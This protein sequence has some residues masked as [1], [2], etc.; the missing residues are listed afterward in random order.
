MDGFENMVDYYNKTTKKDTYYEIINYV[1]THINIINKMPIAKI[2]EETYVSESTITRFVRK[3]GYKD[4]N[5]FKT[6]IYEKYHNDLNSSFR[7][8]NEQLFTLEKKPETFLKDYGDAICEAIQDTV[9][10]FDYLKIDLLID[11]IMYH[12]CAIFAYNQPLTHAKEI[13]NDFIIKNKL[14][15]VGETYDKQLQIASTLNKNSIA[16]ILS[17]YGNYF[18]EHQEIVN[19]LIKNKVPIILVTLNYSS[20]KLFNFKTVIHLSSKSFSEVGGYPMKLFS[21]Y[22]VRRLMVKYK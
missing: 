20:P 9:N 18:N 6:S 3:F 15:Q 16:I 19:T 22:I 4:F 10:T 7:M 17:N 11:D 2:A 13:Q 12:D 8:R 21:E 1:L 14:I 5:S